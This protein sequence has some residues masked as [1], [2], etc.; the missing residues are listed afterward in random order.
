MESK[1][2]QLDFKDLFNGVLIAVLTSVLAV[3]QTSLEAGVLAFDWAQ[4]LNAAILGAG[5]YIL[6]KL[7]TNNMGQLLKRNVRL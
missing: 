4:I 1:L 6:K 3:V 2:L 7:S 5:A